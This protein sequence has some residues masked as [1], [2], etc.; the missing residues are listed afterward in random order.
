VED[1]PTKHSTKYL[2][3]DGDRLLRVRYSDAV[4]RELFSAVA[5]ATLLAAFSFADPVFE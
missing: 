2:S 4:G 5:E 3:V 1:R